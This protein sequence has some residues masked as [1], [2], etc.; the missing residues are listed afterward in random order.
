MRNRVCLLLAAFL[1][2]AG[3]VLAQ[4]AATHETA[5]GDIAAR[6]TPEGDTIFTLVTPGGHVSFT[7][8]GDWPVIAVHS[9]LPGAVAFQ[10]PDPADANTEVSTNLS[11][12]F[13]QS[14]SR[15]ALQAQRNFAK[16]I[17]TKLPLRE[18]YDGWTVAT[19]GVATNGTPFT[20]IDAE[21]TVADVVIAVRL[22][23]PHL[24]GQPGTHIADMRVLFRKTLDS[25]NGDAGAYSLHDGE[26]LRRPDA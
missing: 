19:Q 11:F 24:M 10:I 23:W 21:K 2:C 9:L 20:V 15:D 25:V 26:V 16:P 5:P 3:P 8:G 6:Q 4:D 7:G 18:V 17:G 1:A 12:S 22:A 14:G 13:Y